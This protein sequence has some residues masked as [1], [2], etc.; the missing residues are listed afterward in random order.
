MRKVYMIEG[1]DGLLQ[2]SGQPGLAELC[3]VLQEILGGDEASGCLLE[4]HTLESSVSCVYRLHIESKGRI[5]SLVIKRL[6][7]A[8]AQRNQLVMKR[9]LP[10]VDLSQ[11]APSL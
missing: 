1:L 2:G 8:V 6:E 5:H 7:P 4:Q 11:C 10:A 9:W 3:D